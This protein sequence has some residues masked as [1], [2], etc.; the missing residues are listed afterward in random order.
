MSSVAAAASSSASAYLMAGKILAA[1]TASKFQPVASAVPAADK[2]AISQAARDAFAAAENNSGANAT[3]RKLAE[4]KAKDAL[5]RTPQDMEYLL[6]NDKK[7]SAILDKEN[8]GIGIA[9]SEVDYM[10]KAGGF[11]NSF[12]LLSPAEKELYD[13]AIASGN[14]EAAA[15]ISIIAL[16]RTMGHVAGG[17]EGTTYDPINTEITAANVEK[18]F[19]HSVKD[20]SGKMQAQFQA[21]I[22]FLQNN[23]TKPAAEH[24]APDT[25]KT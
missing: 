22:Q 13:Q 20:P 10:Q 8:K 7:L 5:H 17:A 21:L 16:T 25:A 14:K 1:N 6:A 11:V 4:I 19:R 12:A 23:P 24:S 9:A 18:Y 3:E 15:G 2:V